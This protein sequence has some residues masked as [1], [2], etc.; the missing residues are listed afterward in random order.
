MATQTSPLPISLTRAGKVDILDLVIRSKFEN[1]RALATVRQLMAKDRT[2]GEDALLH[3]LSTEIANFESR[4][5]RKPGLTASQ[6]IRFLLEENG[7]NAN[8]LGGLLG[9]KSHVSEILNGKRKVGIKQA[10]KLGRRFR[11]NPAAFLSLE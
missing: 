4:A 9:G 10:V 11:M 7:L 2:A 1:E 8:D 5:Y 6:R 3:I